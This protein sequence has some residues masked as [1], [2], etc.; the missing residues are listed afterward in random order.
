MLSG[1]RLA[2]AEV[3]KGQ[4]ALGLSLNITIPCTAERISIIELML[5]KQAGGVLSYLARDL[6]SLLHHLWLLRY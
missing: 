6:L 4:A 2:P 1:Q 5:C 3:G